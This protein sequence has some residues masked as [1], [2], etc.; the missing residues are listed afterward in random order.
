MDRATTPAR[1]RTTGRRT[2]RLVAPARRTVDRDRGPGHAA[3]RRRPRRRRRRDGV[4]HPAGRPRIASADVDYAP[5]VDGGGRGVPRH[6]GAGRAAARSW[7]RSSTPWRTS[8]RSSAFDQLAEDVTERLIDLD[9]RIANTRA[10]VARVRALLD[11]ATDIQGSCVSSR[12]SPTA[13]SSLETLLAS[14]RQLEDRVAMSTLTVEIVAAPPAV[15]GLVTREFEPPLPGVAE[16]VA[17][18]WGAFVNGA[19]AVVLVLATIVPFLV[20]AA[21]GARRAL[22]SP[23]SQPEHVACVIR[24]GLNPSLETTHGGGG[25][26][27]AATRRSRIVATTHGRR[28]VTCAHVY[29]YTRN[30]RSTSSFRRWAS[31]PARLESSDRGVRTLR[32]RPSRARR[33]SRLVRRGG[34][35]GVARPASSAEEGE[36]RVAA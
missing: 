2:G 7:R 20:V 28:S 36:P 6:A 4:G 10:S 35:R 19:Y 34:R 16:A 5:D 9:S 12:S 17:D 14:Q 26:Q 27:P 32:P 31:D 8:A 33:G 15:F 3:R 11:A 13:R 18:G 30:P 29:S 24:T 21:L 25:V 1:L 23:C 22:G